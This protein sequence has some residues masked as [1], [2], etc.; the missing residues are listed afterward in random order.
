MS[1][2]LTINPGDIPTAAQMNSYW[3]HT[4][5]T[6]NTWTPTVTQT[7]TV[8]YTASRATYWR[9]GRLIIVNMHLTVTGS[10]TANSTV[11]V[12]L[13]ITAATHPANTVL[14]EG[15][16]NDNSA[17]LSYPNKVLYNSTTQVTFLDGTA[18][19]NVLVG[20][21]GSA[22]SAALANNDI[23]SATFMYEAA[24]G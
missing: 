21:T 10:G 19:T 11:V 2:E 24:A 5:S 17:N 20:L 22:F 15:N 23:I 1:G 3:S 4:G 9:A 8:A 7:G 16:I 12:T 13:P 14:G 18:A 6:W